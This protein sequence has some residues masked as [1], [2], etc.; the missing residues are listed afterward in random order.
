MANRAIPSIRFFLRKKE[1]KK[2]TTTTTKGK[3]KGGVVE[4]NIGTTA[5]L[6]NKSAVNVNIT[7]VL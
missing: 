6:F 4:E 7:E 5:N 2:A 1:K 3:Q